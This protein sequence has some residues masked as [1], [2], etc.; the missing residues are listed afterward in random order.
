MRERDILAALTHPNIARL[1]DAGISDSR[2]PYL[3]MEY[4]AGTA[5]IQSC[6]ERCLTIPGRLQIFV[7]VL[8][9]VQF[10]HA[11]L[12]IHR[13]LKPSN[14]LVT[15]EGRVVLLDFGIGKLLTEE[16]PGQTPLTQISGRALTPDYASPEQIA[17]QALGTA[18]DI[19]SLGVI[20][21]ELLTGSRPYR[22]KRESRV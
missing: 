10:A 22:V 2:Q 17:G 9:A 16:A 21:Y 11:K 19:Y 13:D 1:Y 18:S 14:I 3:A 5:L 7:Q 6:D 4:V 8:E 12:V 15:G 20:L